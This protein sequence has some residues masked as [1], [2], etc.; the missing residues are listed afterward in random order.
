MHVAMGAIVLFVFLYILGI[1]GIHMHHTRGQGHRKTRV[2][3][4]LIK[5]K[6]WSGQSYQ[7]SVPHCNMKRQRHFSRLMNS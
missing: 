6:K 2:T 7:Q 3:M 4:N 5:Q 1:G